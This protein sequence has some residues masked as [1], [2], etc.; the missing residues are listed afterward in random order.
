MLLLKCAK[1][2]SLKSKLIKRQ[3]GGE[4]LSSLGLKTPLS[5]ILL[6]GDVFFSNAIP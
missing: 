3:E 1:C 4:I 6:F 2:G 5:K